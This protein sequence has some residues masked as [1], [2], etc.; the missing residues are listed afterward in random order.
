MPTILTIKQ[1]IYIL[2][3]LK[4]LYVDDYG[5]SR[6]VFMDCEQI[7]HDLGL[8][9]PKSIVIKLSCG[10]GGMNQTY[11]EIQTFLEGEGPF[12]EIYYYGRFVEIM[13]RV[14]PLWFRDSLEEFD[15][16]AGRLLAY[17]KDDEDYQKEEDLI[18]KCAYIADEMCTRYNCYSAD[19]FQVGE[20]ED[21]ELRL[22][23]YGFIPHAGYQQCSMDVVSTL[24]D[25]DNSLEDYIKDCITFLETTTTLYLCQDYS[26][27]DVLEQRYRD[28]EYEEDDGE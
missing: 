27:F 7:L 12:A 19:F 3:E 17:Y 4:K 21:G 13:E 1:E 11:K 9:V 15:G 23:D 22:F 28:Y 26:T 20:N 2:Q 10:I 16:D 6:L 14:T 5:S 18:Y 24:T 8:D 25:V